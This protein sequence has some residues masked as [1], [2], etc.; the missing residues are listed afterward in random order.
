MKINFISI[1]IFIFLSPYYAFSQITEAEIINKVSELGN[2][3]NLNK[4]E[5]KKLDKFNS[6]IVDNLD[7]LKN[8]VLESIYGSEFYSNPNLNFLPQNNI[9]NPENYLI[10]T[11]DELSLN[12]FGIQ[13]YF[14][15]T[16]VD[17]YGRINVGHHGLINIS[18]LT[19]IQA[20][21]KLKSILSNSI[22]GTIKSGET[23]LVLTLDKPKTI[24]VT[25]IGAKRSGNYNISSLSTLFHLLYLGGGPDSINSY[26]IVNVM[27][28]DTLY[29][30]IDLYNF[31]LNGDKQGNLNLKNG[32]VVIIPTYSYRVHVFGKVKRNGMFE[33]KGNKE[34]LS[35]VLKF[36]GGYLSNFSPKNIQVERYVNDHRKIINIDSFQIKTFVLND[37]DEVL[38]KTANGSFLNKVSITGSVM[39]PGRY[40]LEKT[41]NIEDL[42]M[43]AGN[44]INGAYKIKG[45]LWRLNE[46]NSQ[47]PIS[48]DFDTNGKNLNLVNN[49][50]LVIYSYADFNDNRTLVINGE[51]RKQGIYPYKSGMMLSDILILS[52]GITEKGNKQEVEVVRKRKQIDKFNKNQEFNDIYK[53]KI[54]TNFFTNKFNDFEL[55][56]NDI[57]N[58][59][60]NPNS[61][62][63]KNV[64]IMGEVFSPGIYT[65]LNSQERI[66]SLIHRAGNITAFGNI[67]GAKIYR[68]SSI[69]EITNTVSEQMKLFQKYYKVDTNQIDKSYVVSE[70]AKMKKVI[71]K[72]SDAILDPNGYNNII[73]EDGDSVYI[74]T[75]VN[76]VTIEGEVWNKGVVAFNPSRGIR[77]YLNIA[78]GV[79][80][81][82]DKNKIFI[83]R[84]N[85]AGAR[86]RSFFKFIRL[87][88]KVTEG[89]TIYIPKKF[90]NENNLNLIQSIYNKGVVSP[91]NILSNQ[92]S[93]L[94]TTFLSYYLLKNTIK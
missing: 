45:V 9:P 51:V 24:N 17:N 21:K 36:A 88:P 72:L 48:I 31:L 84:E 75:R 19:I 5:N 55:E 47:F 15:K 61:F 40:Q 34:T 14:L 86:T 28:S 68:K 91:L 69:E 10:G 16:T 90:E 64:Y 50:S 94:S 35:D 71:I 4:V 30:Q 26:R 70:I 23:N 33:L 27:R 13:E 42:I 22:Y 54:D 6:V 7:T 37:G 82:A 32:D 29:K 49:D 93:T 63:N 74:P 66:S 20:E 62:I 76:A 57:I 1:L 79:T 78:S 8:K 18:G 52:G 89:A 60:S 56:Y 87:Y 53:I 73:L 85:G 38:I 41:N 3:N 44:F 43:L 39:Y 25:L 46:N 77:Y 12:I 67:E 2:T 83:I 80:N 81:N 59:K 11:G 65:L 92:I 58:V